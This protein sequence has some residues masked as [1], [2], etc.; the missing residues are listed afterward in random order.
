M[1]DDVRVTKFKIDWDDEVQQV[2][3]NNTE[4]VPPAEN[5]A[6][7]ANQEREREPMKPANFSTESNSVGVG[8]MDTS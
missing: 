5:P 1:T 6:S 7:T 4:N 2:N 3:V 8:A